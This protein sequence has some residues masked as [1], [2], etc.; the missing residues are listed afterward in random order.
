M[1]KK[2]FLALTGLAFLG[3]TAFTTIATSQTSEAQ[4]QTIGNGDLNPCAGGKNVC[5]ASTANKER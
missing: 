4:T 3:G 5:C 2:F 1:K